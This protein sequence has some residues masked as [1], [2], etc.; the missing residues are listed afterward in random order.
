MKSFVGS[1][2]FKPFWLTFSSALQADDGRIIEYYTYGSE[3]PDAQILLQ[4]NGSC[5]S[6]RLFGQ[7]T[8]MVTA[9]QDL[10]DPW[11]QHLIAWSRFLIQSPV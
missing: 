8:G 5:G 10:E 1:R 6:A 9:M 4:V 3:E 2:L 11:H 7:M